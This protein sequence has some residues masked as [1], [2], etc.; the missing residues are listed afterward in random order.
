MV[1]VCVCI[2]NK[3]ELVDTATLWTSRDL[4]VLDGDP[5]CLVRLVLS[6]A[7]NVSEGVQRID[8][9]WLL[10]GSELRDFYWLPMALLVV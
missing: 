7:A 9:D 1:A 2:S 4:L 6:G 3:V 10:H 5:H 8:H